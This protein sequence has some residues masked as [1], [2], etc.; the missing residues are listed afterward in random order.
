MWLHENTVI[1]LYFIASRQPLSCDQPPGITHHVHSPFPQRHPPCRNLAARPASEGEVAAAPRVRPRVCARSCIINCPRDVSTGAKAVLMRPRRADGQRNT[2]G[3]PS[4]LSP[5]PPYQPSS[6]LLLLPPLQ[7][8]AETSRGGAQDPS[9][10][11]GTCGRS[12]RRRAGG[13]TTIPH[14]TA[15]GAVKLHAV[16][17]STVSPFPP[18][19]APPTPSSLRRNLKG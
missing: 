17:P 7:V 2:I 13:K 3:V 19:P 15:G 14:V 4:P 8:C 6:P 5:H 10:Q 1:G 18:P 16:Y 9:V 12:Q 11:L